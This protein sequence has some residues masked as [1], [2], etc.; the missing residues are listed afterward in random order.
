M[1]QRY[2]KPKNENNGNGISWE[3]YERVAQELERLAKARRPIKTEEY[4]RVAKAFL[5]L[6]E[7]KARQGFVSHTMEKADD[8]TT[9]AV[10]SGESN[11]ESVKEKYK[12]P[13]GQG[14]F[15]KTGDE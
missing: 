8:A 2:S 13:T 11:V 5:K 6:K 9:E 3:D 7:A 14:Q 4:E 10:L 1:F 15:R 12:E